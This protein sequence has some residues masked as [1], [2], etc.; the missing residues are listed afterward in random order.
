MA[1]WFRHWA[2]ILCAQGLSPLFFNYLFFKEKSLNSIIVHL[3]SCPI[4]VKFANKQRKN[5]RITIYI[6]DKKRSYFFI[7]P[8]LVSGFNIYNN[9]HGIGEFETIIVSYNNS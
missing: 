3:K 1:F 2:T 7:S 4:N 8:L 9:I 6:S 5:K